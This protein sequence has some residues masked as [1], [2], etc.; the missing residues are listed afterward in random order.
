MLTQG[1]HSYA[2]PGFTKKEVQSLMARDRHYY[3]D[4]GLSD[5]F[6]EKAFH[7]AADDMWYPTI[8]ELIKN[9][10]IT[11]QVKSGKLISA[12]KRF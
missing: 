10:V 9:N 11:H 7:T 5:K 12:K 8:A 2:F 6:L 4:K 3:K 1:V